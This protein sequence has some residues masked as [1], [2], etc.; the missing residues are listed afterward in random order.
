ME[1][2]FSFLSDFDGVWTNPV[3]EL[4]AVHTTVIGELAR[5]AEIPT[6]TMEAHYQGFRDAVLKTP[7]QHGWKIDGKL[8]SFVDEDFFAMPTSVGQY[9]DLAPCRTSAGLR[10]A[11]LREYGTVLE[12]L[13]RCYRDSCDAFR[14]EVDHDLTHGAERVLDWLLANGVQVVFA[15]NA[16]GEKI[17]DW[18]AHHG[19]TVEDGRSTE[20]GSAPL[21]VYGRAGKQEVEGSRT[22]AFSGREVHIDRP[23][24]RDILEREQAELGIGDVLS[25]NLALPL[26]M[27]SQGGA[28]APTAVG[29]MHLPHTPDWVLESVGPDEHEIDFLVPHV[30]SLPRLINQLRV[31]RPAP[32]ARARRG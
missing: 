3:R 32:R 14:R 16:P 22:M 27:S 1:G 18:F 15:S 13:D 8:V 29:I 12:F 19:F 28:G 20:P 25:L 31:P 4:D 11:V 2:P 23:Q 21:R 10:D 5:L 7:D 26:A 24:Y 17:I 9:I 6:E 30:T